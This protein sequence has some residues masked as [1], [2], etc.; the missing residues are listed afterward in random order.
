MFSLIVIVVSLFFVVTYCDV[1][2]VFRRWRG[3]ERQVVEG[4]GEGNGLKREL[5]E[6]ALKREEGEILA[7]WREVR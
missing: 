1:H 4:K 5:E 6:V 2:C 7:T 3:L